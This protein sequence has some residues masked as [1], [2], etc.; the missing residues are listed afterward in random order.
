MGLGRLHDES[1]GVREERRPPFR[2]DTTRRFVLDRQTPRL[3]WPETESP[4]GSR[5]LSNL[6]WAPCL[7][8]TASRRHRGEPEAMGCVVRQ[9]SSFTEEWVYAPRALSPLYG[10]PDLADATAATARATG[11]PGYSIAFWPVGWIASAAEKRPPWRVEP[12]LDPVVPDGERER[13][14]SRV[15]SSPL[16]P[17][18]FTLRVANPSV[19]WRVLDRPP[20]LV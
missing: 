10:V 20:S 4:H 3:G 19:Q 18:D 1:P 13:E 2:A 8:A 5:G 17:R 9:R 12:Y 15:V 14:T 16:A 11:T 7:L 6:V